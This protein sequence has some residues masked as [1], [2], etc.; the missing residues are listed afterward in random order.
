MNKKHIR[1]LKPILKK[2]IN[3]KQM[4]R[5]TRISILRKTNGGT[6]VISQ[7]E[8]LLEHEEHLYFIWKQLRKN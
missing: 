1:I 6:E 5:N 8:F 7:L 4:N 3:E 2:L